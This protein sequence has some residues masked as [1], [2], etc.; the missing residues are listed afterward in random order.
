MLDITQLGGAHFRVMNIELGVSYY[1]VAL[2]GAGPDR[3]DLWSA[4]F[5]IF[6]VS[7]VNCSTNLVCTTPHP[8]STPSN[9]PR[10][11]KKK[12][13]RFPPFGRKRSSLL[14]KSGGMTL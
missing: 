5:T 4:H 7:T 11:A 2:V 14:S 3:L 6:R 10:D 9:I 1:F 13:G 12:E 8:N